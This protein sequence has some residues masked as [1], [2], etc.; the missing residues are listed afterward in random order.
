MTKGSTFGIP[1]FSPGF[2]GL[3]MNTLRLAQWMQERGWKVPLLLKD[4]S[5]IHEKAVAGGLDVTVIGPNTRVFGQ[6]KAIAGWVKKHNMQSLLFPYRRDLKAAAFYKFY[7]NRKIKIVYQQ[8]MQVGIPKRDPIHALRYGA[9]DAW[10]SPL[11]Y[12]KQETIEKTRVP[13]HKIHVIPFGLDL[14][15]FEER[16][17][18]RAEARALFRLPQES[19]IIG[20]LGRI[21]PKKG[22]D[23]LVSGIHLLKTTY[24]ADYELL[25]VGDATL[26]EGDAFSKT[27]K[28]LVSEYDL[29]DKIHFRAYQ[30]DVRSFFAAI[31]IFGMPSHGETFGMVTLEAMASGVPVAGTRK[32]GTQDILQD[33]KLGYLFEK[34]NVAD[35]CAQVL[36]M[37]QN[38]SLPQLLQQAKDEVW[39]KYSKELMC[40]RMEELILGL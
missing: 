1:C 15:T 26:N 34:D 20:V 19:K 28:D 12:L 22:Q 25:L 16:P 33:G 5:A 23:L 3:E 27:L 21:D 8:H 17:W 18:T 37:E 31:D 29:N 24:G 7:H 30:P 32:D 6:A 2:G 11:Q 4:G 39:N 38:N 36:K 10:I 14:K 40:E 9:V 35:F 13:A